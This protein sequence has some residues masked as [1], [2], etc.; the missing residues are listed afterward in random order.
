[1]TDPSSMSAQKTCAA[2]P[3]ATSSPASAS[4][5]T[6]CEPP[7]GSTSD[8]S[9]LPLAHAS[10]LARL[11]SRRNRQEMRD[12]SGRS[13]LNSSRSAALQ[14][15]LENKLWARMV[16]RGS[17]LF[18]FNWRRWVS[19]SELPISALRAWVLPTSVNGCSGWPTA[20]TRDWKD[21][22]G[23]CRDRPGKH[24]RLD[25]LGRVAFLAT[26]QRRTAS[27]QMLTGSCATT[28]SGVRLNPAHSRWLMGIPPAWD[29]CVPT[30]MR[31]S[32]R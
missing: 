27:G 4:G 13:W 20:T 8:P 2:T 12:T 24:S 28:G 7:A 16:G 17:R 14:L 10:R 3:N 21:S 9:G 15:S 29:E 1:M 23:M 32:R 25:L 31:S 30:G 26:N 6:P 11:A 22:P 18:G 19:R 5:P